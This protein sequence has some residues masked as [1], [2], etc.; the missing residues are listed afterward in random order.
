MHNTRDFST[1]TD[2][3]D[4]LTIRPVG[5]NIYSYDNELYDINFPKEWAI[6]H[7]KCTGPK[8]C[9]NCA[10]FGSIGGT[11]FAYCSNCAKYDYQFTRG[12]GMWYN[13]CE[14]DID[15]SDSIFD[16]YMKGVEIEDIGD[17]DLNTDKFNANFSKILENRKKLQDLVK[18]SDVRELIIEYT[19]SEYFS[20]EDYGIDGSVIKI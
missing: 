2:Q 10:Y 17:K 5:K 13:Y 8:E 4:P 12:P 1:M 6:N 3:Y 11:F 7:L 20:C 15:N 18:K 16:T 14:F 19:K 9:D